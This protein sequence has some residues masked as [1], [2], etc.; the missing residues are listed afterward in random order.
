VAEAHAD[1]APPGELLLPLA[2]GG[3]GGE[4]NASAAAVDAVAG[5]LADLAG[6]LTDG[7]YGLLYTT[8][9]EGGL[10]GWPPPTSCDVRLNAYAAWTVGRTPRPAAGSALAGP[11]DGLLGAARLWRAALGRQLVADASRAR[12]APPPFGPQPYGDVESLVWAFLSLG[13]AWQP[14][15]C[16]GEVAASG[17]EVPASGGGGEVAAAGASDAAQPTLLRVAAGVAQPSLGGGG[18]DGGGG[19]GFSGAPYPGDGGPDAQCASA[20]VAYDLSLARLVNSTPQLSLGGRAAL[21][22]ALLDAPP[23]GALPRGVDGPAAVA[24][25][26]AALSSDFR[27]V[28]RTAYLAAATGAPGAAPLEG[29]AL[30]LEAVLRAGPAAPGAPPPAL[31]QKLAAHVAGGGMAVGPLAVGAGDYAG[32]LAAGALAGYDAAAGSAAPDLTLLATSGDAVLLRARFGTAGATAAAATVSNATALDAIPRPPGNAS[33]RGNIT[34]AASG[35][36]EASVVAALRFVPAAPLAFPVYR[37]LGVERV[38]QLSGAG[39]PAGPPLRTVPLGAVVTVTLQ[40]T[41]PDDVDGPLV[42]ELPLPGGLEPLDPL[43]ASGG[44]GG[45]GGG[46]PELRSLPPGCAWAG[47]LD[48]FGFGGGGYDSPWWWPWPPCP[49]QET[50]PTRVLFTFPRAPAGAYTV[51]VAAVAATPGDFLLPPAKAYSQR[52]PEL[53]GLSPSARLTVCE[54]PCAAEAAPP[55]A[56][57][58]SCPADCSGAGACD[59]SSGACL[60]DPGRGGDACEVDAAAGGAPAAEAP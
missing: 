9:D 4:F 20:E 50:R 53:L 51:S 30:A 1:A 44:G 23:G 37:G 33:G 41:T 46:G 58:R 29:Q 45:G 17:G 34:F 12:A 6:P 26:L 18:F 35:V 8:Y 60:C 56:P 49:A 52:Q 43:L 14:A 2:V 47:A 31:T 24:K 54:A 38:V 13:P 57:L 40:V 10:Y 27:V 7:R 3:A 55:A 21:A 32:A 5:A 59:A 22:L 19:G 11:W 36:G 16:G 48:G 39:G 42:V 28:S 25:L 15:L